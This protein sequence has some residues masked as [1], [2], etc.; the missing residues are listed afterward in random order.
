VSSLPP[1]D[2]AM[3]VRSQ[4]FDALADVEGRADRRFDQLALRVSRLEKRGG[5]LFHGMSEEMK[6][7]LMIVGLSVAGMV[8]AALI[9][10]WAEKWRRSQ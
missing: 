7:N 10:A 6:M 4:V 1:T 5:K 9:Q 3:L 8:A 2:D